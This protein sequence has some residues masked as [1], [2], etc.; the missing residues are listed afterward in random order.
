MNLETGEEFHKCD[1][2]L[3]FPFRG[4]RGERGNKMSGKRTKEIEERKAKVR[5]REY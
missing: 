1:G 5:E 4:Q 2:G 3:G